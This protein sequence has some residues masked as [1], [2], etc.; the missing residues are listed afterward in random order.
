M[1]KS[2]CLKQLSPLSSLK[3]DRANGLPLPLRGYVYP[4]GNKRIS[5]LVGPYL[6]LKDYA[7]SVKSSKLRL[8]FGYL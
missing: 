8:P 7:T 1:A 2:H 3:S 6:G 5:V 4:G